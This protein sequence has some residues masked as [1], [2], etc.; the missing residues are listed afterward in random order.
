M[1]DYIKNNITTN[2]MSWDTCSNPLK[3]SSATNIDQT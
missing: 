3:K 1:K 2:K